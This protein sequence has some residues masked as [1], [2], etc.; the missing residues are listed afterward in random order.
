MAK[1]EYNTPLERC[2]KNGA[3]IPAP[4]SSQIAPHSSTSLV[5]DDDLDPRGVA[6][7][8]LVLDLFLVVR[9]HRAAALG[10]LP[11]LD[12]EAKDDI[13][14]IQEI[15]RVCFILVIERGGGGGGGGG[16]PPPP[17]SSQLV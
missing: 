9:R 11:R 14:A 16:P 10:Q 13:A 3:S 6:G 2:K 5:I 15:N 8:E 12:I 1:G 7:V 17:P 4:P